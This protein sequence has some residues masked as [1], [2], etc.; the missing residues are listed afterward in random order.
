MGLN[1]LPFFSALGRTA[2]GALRA[3]ELVVDQHL[4]TLVFFGGGA[5]IGGNPK[6]GV[7]MALNGLAEQP[8]AHKIGDAAIEQVLGCQAVFGQFG[9]VHR[10]DLPSAD[11]DCVVAVVVDGVRVA[12][13]F[14]LDDGLE[15]IWIDAV[16]CR[17][18][19][20]A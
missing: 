19:F 4:V 15:H 16:V 20:G 5:V 12:A 10:V 17:C 11:I 9:E 18:F 6:P 14:D 13:G 3:L 7:A 2:A 8:G 1:R